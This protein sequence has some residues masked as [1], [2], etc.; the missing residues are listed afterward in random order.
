MDKFEW[1][2]KLCSQLDGSCRTVIMIDISILG[3]TGEEIKT[4]TDLFFASWGRKIQFINWMYIKQDKIK[5][6]PQ[7]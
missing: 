5:V 2:K 7:N 6:I 1:R 3:D 4:N